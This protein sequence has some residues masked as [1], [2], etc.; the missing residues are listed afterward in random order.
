M[1]VDKVRIKVEAGKGGDGRVS[2]RRE[3]FVE[4]GGPDGGD[5]GDGGDVVAVASNNQNTLASFRYKKQLAAEAGK[6]GDKQ[7]KHGRSG[8][9]LVVKLPVGTVIA[10]PDGEVLADMTS[11]GQSVVIAKGGSGGF[12]NAHF[13]SSRRQAPRV[14]EIGE[15]GEELDVAFELKMI[16]DVGLVGLPNAGKS[17]LLARVSNARPEI[18]DYPFT[19]LKPNLGMAD[20]NHTTSVLLADIP[21][22]IKGASH[23][24]GLGDEF[25]RHVERTKL[26]VHL[27]DAYQ[28]DI[29]AAYKTIQQE[30]AD[31]S[32]DLSK[33]PQIVALNKIDGLDEEII[34]DQLAKLQKAAGKKA[35]VLAISAKS[36]QGSKELL[37]E[38]QSC[39]KKSR[40]KIPSKLKPSIP[41]IKLPSRGNKWEVTKSGKKFVISGPKIEKFAKRTDFGNEDAVTRL[42]DIMHKMGI[43]H[44]LDRKG[45]QPKDKI[46]IGK[47]KIGSIDY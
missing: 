14:A 31:Y 23:G 25:L 6:N 10:K 42:R 44:E 12:G 17:T 27:V 28:D 47:E 36:G 39:L 29:A 33:R 26:L 24:K 41:V 22:L 37:F 4:R 2:F 43:T 7:K 18:A 20:I 5:G 21:G 19:T 15:P 30:L 40:S 3:K 1:F 11:D 16:A 8:S 34:N 13:T 32:I 35:K 46:Q 38:V 9:D 45:A